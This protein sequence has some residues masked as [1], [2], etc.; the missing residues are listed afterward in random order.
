MIQRI[1]NLNM[2]LLK[3]YIAIPLL[4]IV[5][6]L[7][8]SSTLVHLLTFDLAKSYAK[9]RKISPKRLIYIDRNSCQ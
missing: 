1:A 6:G 5:L 7:S 2:K 3:T 8:F 4:L 9:T